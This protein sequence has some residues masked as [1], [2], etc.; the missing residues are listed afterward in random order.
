M[1]LQPGTSLLK[2]DSTWSLTSSPTL[3]SLSSALMIIPAFI[4]SEKKG[5]SF[6]I[7]YSSCW[8]LGWSDSFLV[9]FIENMISLA[10]AE[11]E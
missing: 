8:I 10:E 3:C 5:E 9:D 6:I 4:L 1:H 7:Q 2:R 11:Q